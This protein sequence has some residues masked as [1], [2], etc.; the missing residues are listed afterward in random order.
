MTTRGITAAVAVSVS[1][2]LAACSSSDSTCPGCGGSGGTVGVLHYDSLATEATTAGLVVRPAFL[3]LIVAAMSRGAT[4]HTA[5]G[6]FNSAPQTYS[7]VG[8][9]VVSSAAPT[10]STM[11]DSVDLM[12]AW[13]RN[14]AAQI[15]VTQ[16]AY[17]V[18][19]DT[20]TTFNVAYL[21]DSSQDG[22]AVKD[23]GTVR[24]IV[25][26]PGTACAFTTVV[27][28][29]YP[30]AAPCTPQSSAWN[31]ATQLVIAP[32][33]TATPV[34]FPS[35]ATAASVRI[36]L[37]STQLVQPLS[38]YSALGVAKIFGAIRGGRGS[39]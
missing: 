27:N 29:F 23:S 16:I 35:L 36:D 3:S 19:G 6:R 39:R 10:D 5:L 26:N 11:A 1:A 15:L 7:I 38:T 20:G 31:L 22:P 2:V 33:T 12:V 8:L 32:D 21:P 4:V 18:D 17:G 9:R 30:V 37:G 34:S 14:T 25:T 28:N 24:V 13:V